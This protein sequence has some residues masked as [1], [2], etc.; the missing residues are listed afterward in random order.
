MAGNVIIIGGGLIGASIA[1]DARDLGLAVSVVDPSP[2]ARDV[3]EQSFT[4]V[5]ENIVEVEALLGADSLVILAHPVGALTS[6]LSQFAALKSHPAALFSD[7]LG[8]K[9]FVAEQFASILP[10]VRF[11]RRA[12]DDRRPNRRGC[13]CRRWEI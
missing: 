12:S 3:L 4:N 10:K 11:G 9:A 2:Q 6:V 13:C 5:Y 7:C 1:H 8:V